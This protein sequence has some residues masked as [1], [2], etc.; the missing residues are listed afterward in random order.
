MQSKSRTKKH[1]KYVSIGITIAVVIMMV[2]SGPVSAV[3]MEIAGLN[4]STHTKGTS[5]SFDVTATIEDTDSYVP[6]DSFSLGI[7]GPT[8]KEIEFF[9]NGKALSEV[10]GITVKAVT[11]P[12]PSEYGEGDGYGYDSGLGYGYDFGYGYGYGYGYG[13]GGEVVEYKYTITLDTTI[14]D[15]GDYTAVLSLNTGD[16]AKPSFESSSASFTIASSS[17]S[18]GGS[19]GGSGGARIVPAEDTEQPEDTTD[20]TNGDD[21]AD[22]TTD[23]ED[24]EGIDDTTSDELPA[25]TEE[26]SGLPGFEAVFAIAGLLAVAFIVRR[27]DLE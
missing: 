12:L 21:S 14:L 6:I 3:S 7:T 8:D 10:S 13:A 2:L 27:K 25:T 26:P 11:V 20:E 22:G 9:T 17:T 1:G 24:N 4:G 23:S 19:S 18:S 15:T 16:E 5:V